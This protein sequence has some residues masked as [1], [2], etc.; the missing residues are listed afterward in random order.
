MSYLNSRKKPT[1]E[2][3]YADVVI[4]QCSEC[5]CWSRQEFVHVAEP[6]FPVYKG[7]MNR[8]AKYIRIE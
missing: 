5:N 8:E 4:W 2:H 1:S 7:L 3:I 6:N